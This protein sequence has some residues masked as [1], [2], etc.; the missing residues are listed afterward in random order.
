M[1]Q[2]QLEQFAGECVEN[3]AEILLCTEKDYVK[4]DSDLHLPLMVAWTRVELELKDGIEHW[5]A[6]VDAVQTVVAK[7]RG[8]CLIPSKD[9]ASGCLVDGEEAG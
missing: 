6:F 5:Q 4:L 7:N 9:T 1:T 3:G 2:A 8:T